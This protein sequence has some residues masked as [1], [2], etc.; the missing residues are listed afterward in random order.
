MR[1]NCSSDPE[2]LLEFEAEFLKFGKLLRSLGQFIRIVKDQKKNLTGS[3]RFLRS[4]KL[5]RTI[6]IQIGKKYWD[7]DICGKS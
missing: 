2:K 1:K 4:N 6:E 3:W 5:H 7:L